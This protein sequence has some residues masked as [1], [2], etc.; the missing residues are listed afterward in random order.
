VGCR[1]SAARLYDLASRA[2]VASDIPSANHIL[3]VVVI[4]IVVVDS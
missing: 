4:I 1:Q 3:L 2:G